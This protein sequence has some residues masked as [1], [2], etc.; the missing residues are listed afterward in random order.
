M[1]TVIDYTKVIVDVSAANGDVDLTRIEADLLPRTLI[2]VIGRITRGKNVVDQVGIDAIKQAAV[3]KLPY[4]MAY[5]FLTNEPALNQEA[6]FTY[7][8]SSQ[9]EDVNRP[10]ALWVDCEND[11]V[12]N[13]PLDLLIARQMMLAFTA[14]QHQHLGWYADRSDAARLLNSDPIFSDCPPW[15]DAPDGDIQGDVDR[16]GAC[17]VQIDQLPTKGAPGNGRVDCNYIANLSVL[18][19]LC[20]LTNNEGLLD[21][22]LFIKGND[23]WLW[24]GAHL[25]YLGGLPDVYSY[26]LNRGVPVLDI[27]A[28]DQNAQFFARV[29]AA[30]AQ[31]HLTGNLTGTVQLS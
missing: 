17:L 28:S 4:R 14:D 20:G 7:V 11:P 31:L 9:F 15:I 27:A 12:F 6:W 22:Q 29:Q 23:V 21:M 8:A 13:A 24:G 18:N 25:I 19:S 1:V 16:L 26:F 5:H 10:Q 3:M 2:G 30:E